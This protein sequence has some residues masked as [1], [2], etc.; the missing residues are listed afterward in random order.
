MLTFVA[1]SY[2]G[3]FGGPPPASGAEGFESASFEIGE[4][5]EVRRLHDTIWVVTS[6]RP[7]SAN[8]VVVRLEDGTVVLADTPPTTAYTNA[9]LDWVGGELEPRSIVAINGHYHMDGSGGN[10]LLR[11]RDIPVWA[12]RN[13]AELLSEKG[14]GVLGELR[15]SAEGTEDEGMWDD[16][17]ISEPSMTFDPKETEILRF[18]NQEVHLIFPGASHSTD[19]IVIYFPDQELLFGGCGVKAGRTLGYLGDAD[20]DTWPAAIARLKKLP[21]R[22]VIPGHGSRVDPGLLQHTLDL[23]EAHDAED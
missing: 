4:N 23:L 9:L 3:I 7:W 8:S 21:A 2:L 13:T 15:R 20:L 14:Q 19:L 5:L 1:I 12:S 16:E 17:T 11:E 18:G 22:W 10:T 6:P